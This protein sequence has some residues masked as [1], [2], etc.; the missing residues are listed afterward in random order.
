MENYLTNTVRLGARILSGERDPSVI[1]YRPQKTA[2]LA[3]SLPAFR[4]TAPEKHGVSSRRITKLL[5][6]LEREERASVQNLLILKDG[7]L[8]SACSRP[9]FDRLTPHL[10]HSMSKTVTGMLILSLIGSGSLSLEDPALSFF[11]E[12]RPK[13]SRAEKITVEDLLRMS[14]GVRFGEAGSVT[15]E[16]WTEAYFAS[17]LK[18]APSEGF[19]YNS[20]NTYLLARV[21]ERA[22]ERPFEELLR[23]RLFSPIGIEEYFW[24][25]SPE[26]CPAGGFGLYLSCEDWAKLGLLLM[27]GGVWQGTRLLPEDLVRRATS[28]Q[29]EYSREKK[30]FFAYGWQIWADKRDTGDFLFNG[31]LGQNVLVSPSLGMVISLNCSN[32]EFFQDSPTLRLLV[33]FLD[34]LRA[35]V[36]SPKRDREGVR[37]LASAER[38]FFAGRTAAKPLPPPTPAHPL[39]A[40]IPLLRRFL[41]PPARQIP[42]AWKRL[43]GKRF[44]L[45]ESNA[46]LLPFFVRL[47]ANDLA[48][49]LSSICFS[50]EDGRLFLSAEE[51]EETQKF[52]IGLWEYAPGVIGKGGEVYRVNTL[53]EYEE[54]GG[55]SRYTVELCC[56]E[57]PA[58]HHFVLTG[59]DGVFTLSDRQLPNRG[60]LTPFL[61]RAKA[62]KGALGRFY[63]FHS[64]VS[65]GDFAERRLDELFSPETVC[66]AEDAPDAAQILAQDK[67]KASG[68]YA[69]VRKLYALFRLFFREESE[70]DKKEPA[71]RRPFGVRK[72]KKTEETGS[73]DHPEALPAGQ[74]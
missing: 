66:V 39:L 27:Q 52:E 9:G 59:R 48:G 4:R 14:S 24:V 1:A 69:A 31:M 34:D 29:N 11:P 50:E 13:D 70:S 47:M 55:I 16:K 44:L 37:A 35:G 17:G 57:L 30:E 60:V 71:A 18:F 53:G 49:R 61:D 72:R 5:Y 68:R 40:K 23:E 63:A 20:M 56:P 15:E 38:N 67:E 74:S 8:L 36:G 73:G 65:G 10:S 32:N 54:S 19:H 28:V 64:R 3:A 33:G 45:G 43:C 51:G 7:E 22:G 26:G 62:G 6:D 25:K 58:E 2:P 12:I 46:S 41:K 21:A 42:E